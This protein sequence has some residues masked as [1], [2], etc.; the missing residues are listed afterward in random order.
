[1]RIKKFNESN[2]LNVDFKLLTDK[3]NDI[4]ECLLDF[5]DDSRI[6][7]LIHR[8]YYSRIKFGNQIGVGYFDPQIIEYDSWLESIKNN[9][10][11]PD[12]NIWLKNQTILLQCHI[13]LPTIE[14]QFPTGIKDI[15]DIELILNS[16]EKIKLKFDDVSLI[17]RQ[18]EVG[19]RIKQIGIIGV[20]FNLKS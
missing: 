20:Y 14:N 3:I 2:D 7:Y 5:E 19:S 8:V 12:D 1:M 10:N 9:L 4:R 11:L 13:N 18:E 16:I 6:K 17:F 15:D